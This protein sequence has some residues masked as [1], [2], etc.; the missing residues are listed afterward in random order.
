MKIDKKDL[1]IIID[2]LVKKHDS[3]SDSDVFVVKGKDIF[4]EE[5]DSMIGKKWYLEKQVMQNSYILKIIDDFS[6]SS[7]GY[8]WTKS[9]LEKY[10]L[11]GEGLRYISGQMDESELIGEGMIKISFNEFKRKIYDKFKL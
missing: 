6:R 11:Y 10:L 8:G 2:D 9:D 1:K 5:E 7:G 3:M 4:I